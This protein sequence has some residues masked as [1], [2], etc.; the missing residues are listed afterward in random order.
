MLKNFTKLNQVPSIRLGITEQLD[1]S[2][3]RSAD[4]ELENINYSNRN[5]YF[6]KVG[7]DIDDL[8]QAKLVHGNE[9]LR[10]GMNDRGKIPDIADGLVTKE[11]GVILGV[12]AA[13]CFP[14]YFYDP[15]KSG[16]GLAHA[17][18]RG[19]AKNIVHQVVETMKREFDSSADDI[20]VY[21]G[22]GIRQ[23][24]FSIAPDPNIEI[25]EYAKVSR[26]GTIYVDLP[27]IIK[28]QLA[29]VG[30]TN[31]HIDDGGEC[32]FCLSAKYF[33]HRRDQVSPLETMLAY[34]CLLKK[35]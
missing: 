28:H 22:P 13:D 19:V 7:F 18:W 33:S 12:T 34:I 24:H 5:R 15:V 31:E 32:T 4:V 11:R 26:E 1:G 17:G 27:S 8:V 10:V 16:I 25:P 20:L 30:I 6:K 29:E 9:I 2:M 21:L 23:C 14:I 3:L 35:D